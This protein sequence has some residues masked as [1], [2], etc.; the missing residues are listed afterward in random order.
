MGYDETYAISNYEAGKLST[1]AKLTGPSGLEM[2]VQTTAPGLHLYT[3]NGLDE[4]E[5]KEDVVYTMRGGV[6][7]ETHYFP[8]AIDVDN[9]LHDFKKGEM[10]ILRPGGK[11]YT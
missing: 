7:L 8:N 4:V 5:G 1:V 3:G 6:C 9:Q 10:P 2:E 11:D